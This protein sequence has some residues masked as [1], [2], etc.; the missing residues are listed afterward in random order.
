MDP[1]LGKLAFGQFIVMLIANITQ[2]YSKYNTE[3]CIP[4]ALFG[5]KGYAWKVK[6]TQPC[7]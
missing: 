2:R 5:I 1:D 7:I 3:S 6:E 4:L